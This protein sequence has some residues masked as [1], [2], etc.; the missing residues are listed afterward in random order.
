MSSAK[1]T[2]TRSRRTVRERV[3]RGFR[4]RPL[5]VGHP[6]QLMTARHFFFGRFFFDFLKAA[7]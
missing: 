5:A 3:G 4:A 1:T 6:C 2:H 7:G